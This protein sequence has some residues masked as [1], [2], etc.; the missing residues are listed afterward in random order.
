MIF[1]LY[2]RFICKFFTFYFKNETINFLANRIITNLIIKLDRSPITAR[3][4]TLPHIIIICFCYENR[5]ILK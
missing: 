4:I 5:Y 3:I 1:F 2:G